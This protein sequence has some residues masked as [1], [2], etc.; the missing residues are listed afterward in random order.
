MGKPHPKGIKLEIGVSDTQGK[1]IE[2]QILGVVD[3]SSLPY[4]DDERKLLTKVLFDNAEIQ[5]KEK[6]K[7]WFHDLVVTDGGS[8]VRI[9]KCGTINFPSSAVGLIRVKDQ[10]H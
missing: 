5:H 4:G 3:V 6:R 1:D 9:D 8:C 10:Y 2:Y 7:F